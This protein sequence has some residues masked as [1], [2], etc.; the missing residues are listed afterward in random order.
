MENK[1]ALF[2]SKEIRKVWCNEEWFFS[3]VDV[4]WAL[5]DSFN[6]TDI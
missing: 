6:P 2:E 4:A 5:T 3:I 1:L